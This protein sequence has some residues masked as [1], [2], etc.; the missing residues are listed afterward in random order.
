MIRRPPRSTLFPYTTLFRSPERQVVG[1][2]LERDNGEDRREELAH[3]R[4]RD[5][6]RGQGRDRAIVLPYERDDGG[7]DFLRDPRDRQAALVGGARQRDQ[8]DDVVGLQ[9]GPR[10]VEELLT[11]QA[12]RR[13]VVRLARSEERRVGKECRSRWSPYH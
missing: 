3:R 11:V 10:A 7:A 1:E 4:D 2:E 13:R 8:E 9:R 6:L 5:R 12:E